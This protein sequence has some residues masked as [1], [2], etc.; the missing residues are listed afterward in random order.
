[1]L[2]KKLVLLGA[3]AGL[4]LAGVR[5]GVAESQ[6][7]SVSDHASTSTDKA[8]AVVASESASAEDG[9]FD[10]VASASQADVSLDGL[11]AYAGA[12]AVASKSFALA[13][14]NY[15]GEVFIRELFGHATRDGLGQAGSSFYLALE[16]SACEWEPNDALSIVTPIPTQDAIEYGEVTDV[17]AFTVTEATTVT[18]RVTVTASAA[19]G[20]HVL[21]SG[22]D[23][24]PP[25][26]ELG[27]HGGGGATDLKGIIDSLTVTEIVE[28]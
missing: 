19:T 23:D 17:I 4:A 16:C 24:V 8:A 13:P 7:D 10:L 15:E 18:L 26:T 11:P 3:V 5:P 12:V 20:Q 9:S 25:T 28:E 27:A 22:T 2:S 6:F 1:M 14:G 21:V